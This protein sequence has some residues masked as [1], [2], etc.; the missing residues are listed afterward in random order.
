MTSNASMRTAV[1]FHP[2]YDENGK[3]INKDRNTSTKKYTCMNCGN[4]YKV[5]SRVDG[6]W[7]K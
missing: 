7:Y 6:S 2:R 5:A 3:Q 1:A 4:E